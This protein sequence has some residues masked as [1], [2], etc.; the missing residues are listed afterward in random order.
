M[1]KQGGAKRLVVM[2]PE[3]PKNIH[4]TLSKVLDKGGWRD[5]TVYGST[6]NKPSESEAS[7]GLTHAVLM[8]FEN[9]AARKEAMDAAEF[10]L[11]VSHHPRPMRFDYE[12]TVVKQ[13][14][15]GYPAF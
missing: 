12:P 3:D 7:H 5:S 10:N 4:T 14:A 1:G 13:G 6:K 2:T 15:V 9:A 8:S 11:A